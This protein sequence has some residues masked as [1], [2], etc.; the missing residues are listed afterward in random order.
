M[1]VS[2]QVVS[3]IKST[4]A[5]GTTQDVALT[6]TPKAIQVFS[7]NSTTTALANEYSWS[8][9]FSDGTN[10]AAI[11][12]HSD[13]GSAASDTGRIH[14]N[15][16]VYIKLDEAT[17]TTT[18]R[19]R[20]SVVFQTNNLRFTW[21]LNDAVATRITVIA[22]GG[23][24]ITGVKVNT[25]DINETVNGNTEDYTGLG[26]TPIGDNNTILF[27]LG[28]NHT[29]VSSSAPTTTSIAQFG[30]ATRA[31]N[32]HPGGNI[33]Q[34]MIGN[35]AENAQADSDTWRHMSSDRCFAITNTIGGYDNYGYLNSWISGGFRMTWDDAA[36]S[37]TVKFSYMV[38][39]GGKWDCGTL[40]SPTSALANQDYAVDAGSQTPKGLMLLSTAGTLSAAINND[41]IYSIAATDG[42]NHAC[43]S[44][45]DEDAQATM[46]GYRFHSTDTTVYRA[47]VANGVVSDLATFDSFSTDNFRLD[48]TT[49]SANAQIIHWIIIADQS[50]QQN[51]TKD[52]GDTYNVTDTVTR[53]KSAPRGLA[54]TYNVTESLSVTVNHVKSISESYNVTE[55]LSKMQTLTRALADTYNVSDA[56]TRSQILTRILT[57]NYNV[58]ETVTRIYNA[59][60]SLA[61]TYNVTEALARMGSFVRLINESYNVVESVNRTISFNRALADTYNVTDTVARSQILTRTLAES[62][63][64]TEAISRLISFFRLLADTYNVT[65]ILDR[66]QILTRTINETYDVTDTL[67]RIQTSI[68]NLSDTYDVTEA[69]TK[70]QNLTRVL[71]DTYNVTDFVSNA[72]SFVV[73]LEE[74]YDVT[75]TITRSLQLTREL[76]DT[77]NVT[78]NLTRLIQ[79]QRLVEETFDVNETL[80]RQVLLLRTLSDTYNVTESVDRDIV[81]AG[82]HIF[83]ELEESYNV[84][85]TVNRDLILQRLLEESYNVTDSI[86]KEGGQEPVIIVTEESASGGGGQLF[87]LSKLKRRIVRKTIEDMLPNFNFNIGDVPDKIYIDNQQ[88]FFLNPEKEPQNIIVAPIRVQAKLYNQNNSVKSHVKPIKQRRLE[89]QLE[90]IHKDLET[91]KISTQKFI[92]S[93]P[94]KIYVTNYKNGKILDKE[95]TNSVSCNLKPI[96]TN[97]YNTILSDIKLIPVNNNAILSRLKI[98]S[99]GYSFSNIILNAVGLTN[100]SQNNLINSNVRIKLNTHNT[101]ISKILNAKKE[102]K[103][104]IKS[105]L[106]NKGKITYDVI[107]EK[108]LNTAKDDTKEHLH[109]YISTYQTKFEIEKT[110][111]NKSLDTLENR[112]KKPLRELYDKVVSEYGDKLYQL[113]DAKRKYGKEINDLIRTVTTKGYNISI[114][115]VTR[116]TERYD[117]YL[118]EKDIQNVKEQ[119][120]KSYGH[121]WESIEKSIKKKQKR[122]ATEAILNNRDEQQQQQNNNNNY[123]IDIIPLFTPAIVDTTK[124]EENKIAPIPQYTE[125]EK[126]SNEITSEMA[127]L[128]LLKG[129]TTSILAYATFDKLYQMRDILN[130]RNISIRYVYV[131]EQDALVCKYCYINDY[132]LTGREYTF[133]EYAQIPKPPIHLNCRCRLI[134]KINNRLIIK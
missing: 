60:R 13:D 110:K 12:V 94:N 59:L 126:P 36:A 51:I 69:I 78:D 86:H 87:N 55:S 4:G 8:H 132:R 17:P 67:Q 24:D 64:V 121:I 53:L 23:S 6:F 14:S 125:E 93:I 11:S 134:L 130:Q 82:D 7:C 47:M 92:E 46:D 106:L 75:D 31:Y 105:I 74:I 79:L 83:V 114:D 1:P 22:Y 96:P 120:E 95:L 65:E 109:Y 33:K 102:T 112:Y 38:I 18:V 70:L 113:E 57:E 26:F 34:V 20:G 90:Q 116:A 108:L 49:K 28:I 117:I 19:C 76:A 73:Q 39:N 16:D 35:N 84:T 111:T 80:V 32:P 100:K 101:A 41:A 98:N 30:V 52:V 3:F 40:T 50:S 77:Y 122:E 54:D 85:D 81:P 129:I 25:V 115:Y 43:H 99:D 68:R 107:I 131:T 5:N 97:Y 128:L 104:N 72:A 21:T 29:A 133:E 61:D 124:K 2:C 118:T 10:H 42:T 63:D 91:R 45:I 27:T 88:A 58:T 9:G 15:A 123:P 119:T 89:I 103:R 66:S 56:I 71:T 44:A 127:I 62:Y 37:A 48:Y